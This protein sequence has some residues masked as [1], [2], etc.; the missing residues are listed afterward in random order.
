MIS[1]LD[2]V[3]YNATVFLCVVFS[4][5]CIRPYVLNWRHRASLLQLWSTGACF[6]LESI[7]CKRVFFFAT[8][9]VH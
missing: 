7:S 5:H 4:G 2:S 9:P 6:Q 1:I 8:G 3:F